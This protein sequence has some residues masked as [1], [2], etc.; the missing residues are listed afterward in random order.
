MNQQYDGSPSIEIGKKYRFEVTSADEAVERIKRQMGPKAKVV[1][2]RQK[3]GKGLGRILASPKMEIVAMIPAD[4]PGA[5]AR[6]ALGPRKTPTPPLSSLSPYRASAGFSTSENG[7]SGDASGHP[8][9][10]PSETPGTAET[11][12]S[13]AASGAGD[14][15]TGSAET[16]SAETGE[17]AAAGQPETAAPA[18][19]AT[20]R[21]RPDRPHPPPP[22][23]E[24]PF[25][26]AR[27]EDN[28][29]PLLES[30]EQWSG[31]TEL[32]V[33]HAL[34]ELGYWLKSRFRELPRHEMTRR[35]AFFGLAGSGKTTALCKMLS[36]TVF[37]EGCKPT[38]AKLESRDANPADA[39]RVFCDILGVPFQGIT[40]S[41]DP[42]MR[43]TEHL[44]LDM[45]GLGL[46]QADEWRKTG[47]TFDLLGISTRVLVVNVAYD[48]ELIK[49][50]IRLSEYS[51]A[52]HIVLTHLDEGAAGLKIWPVILG[53]GLTPWFISNGQD[54]GGDFSFYVCEQLL[55][56]SLPPL[57]RESATS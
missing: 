10:P 18:A 4:D 6:P 25:P 48:L 30:S 51:G 9:A 17:N 43:D 31:M 22:S 50:Q 54:L 56:D 28:P 1:S 49:E 39:L 53:S 45:P 7:R 14:A 3:V 20:P 41:D 57:A 55:G 5:S 42:A 23:P 46:K 40:D 11:E 52:T 19:D 35:I 13:E 26:Q 27:V 47:H 2:V 36:D 37:K 44:L 24:H 21:R 12:R 33:R 8:S 16:G 29:P 15:E 32:P 38:V 34:S